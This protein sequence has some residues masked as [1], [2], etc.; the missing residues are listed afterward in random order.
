[1]LLPNVSEVA[2]YVV[3]PGIVETEILRNWKPS[4]MLGL[5]F[6]IGYYFRKVRCENIGRLRR[7]DTP[8]RELLLT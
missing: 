1:M 4:F 8:Q 7:M 2:T 5:L 3:H 6:S